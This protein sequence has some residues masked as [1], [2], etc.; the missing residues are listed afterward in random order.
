MNLL[1]IQEVANWA[2]VSTSHIFDQSE[3]KPLTYQ[4]TFLSIYGLELCATLRS[5]YDLLSHVVNIIRQMITRNSTPGKE[6]GYKAFA[7]HN[8]VI[9]VSSFLQMTQGERA[10]G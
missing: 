9:T 5:F 3:Y 4:K 10:C 7:R 6:V 8:P 2:K 1:T